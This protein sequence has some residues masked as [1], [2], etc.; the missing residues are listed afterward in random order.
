MAAFCHGG[1]PD[2]NRKPLP[3]RQQRLNNKLRS[4]RFRRGRRAGGELKAGGRGA[5]AE[6]EGQ[7]DLQLA[8]DLVE[9]HPG[10]GAFGSFRSM[11]QNAWAS[12]ARVTWR[13]QPVQERPSKW[14]SPGPVFSSR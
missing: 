14:S 6:D 12:A 5:C 7:D 11:V 4:V 13:C 9:G 10:A 3:A 2:N 1:T 8:Q